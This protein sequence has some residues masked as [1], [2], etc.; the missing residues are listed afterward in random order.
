[1]K[2]TIFAQEQKVKDFVFNESVVGVFPDM[3][4]RSVPGYP[5]IVSAMGK[6]AAMYCKDGGT[7]FDL[8]TSLGAVAMS[9]REAMVAK[10]K[11]AQIYAVDSSKPMIEKLKANSTHLPDFFPILGDAEEVIDGVG[12]DVVTMNLVLQF[13]TPERR[14]DV[15][16]TI[17]NSLKEGGAF[18]IT[19]KFY[20]DV[21]ENNDD[22]I[23]MHHE[24]KAAQ[25]YSPVEIQQKAD[26]IR[27]VMLIDTIEKRVDQLE[28]IGYSRCFIW[29]QCFNF[30]SMV[31][32]K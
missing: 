8:G 30:Y 18:L 15:L 21:E 22:L 32:I 24:F 4:K 13:I 2:D 29:Y 20:D 7:V 11:H 5:T 28:E 1:M 3:V 25:G 26:S 31:A 17:F 12:A 9:V 14:L 27:D 23:T 6:L 19:E 16:K 10:G